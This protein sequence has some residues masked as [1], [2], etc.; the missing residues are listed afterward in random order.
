MREPAWEGRLFG[1]VSALTQF[2]RVGRPLETVLKDEALQARCI[3]GS[4]YPLPAIN[5]LMQTRA[6][7]SGGFLTEAEREALNEI[8]RH[9]PLL[10][11]FVMKR[12]VRAGGHRLADDVF[13]ARPEVFPRLARG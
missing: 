5:A 3:N 10:F 6:V 9:D 8:D 2:N 4:D 13:T 7:V 12:T 1:E 11:D